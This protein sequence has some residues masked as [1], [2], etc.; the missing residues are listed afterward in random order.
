MA[1]APSSEARGEQLTRKKKEGT[2]SRMVV[3]EEQANLLRP[4]LPL[5]VEKLLISSLGALQ[6]LVSQLDTYQQHE[7]P[8]RHR[9][10][11]RGGPQRAR[12]RPFSEQ[13]ASLL[14]S[15]SSSPSPLLLYL[16]RRAQKTHRLATWFFPS[17]LLRFFCGREGV[18]V[19]HDLERREGSVGAWKRTR[20]EPVREEERRGRE[21]LSK[22]ERRR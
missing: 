20:R 14:E 18:P 7:G 15:S 1:N 6:R 16:L 4:L 22:K 9:L 13:G 19:T 11:R 8:R 17:L 21:S 12:T 5:D 10:T 2:T 3:E